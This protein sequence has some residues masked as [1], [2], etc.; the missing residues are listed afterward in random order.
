MR[1]SRPSLDILDI[2]VII[3]VDRTDIVGAPEQF[4]SVIV[5]LSN[6]IRP[7]IKGCPCRAVPASG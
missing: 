2:A 1:T 4:V 3:S 6:A 5:P 7:L